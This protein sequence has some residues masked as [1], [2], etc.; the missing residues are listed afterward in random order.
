MPDIYFVRDSVREMDYISSKDL[1]SQIRLQG[2]QALYL[3]TFEE[4]TDHLKQFLAPGDLLVTMGAGN[5]WEIADE[6]VRGLGVD[7]QDR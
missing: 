3:K 7:R 6:I 4:I 2:G 5:V 1:V